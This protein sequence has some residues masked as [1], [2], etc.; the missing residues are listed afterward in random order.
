MPYENK[1][2]SFIMFPND[3]AKSD[4]AP[5]WKGKIVLEDG[6]EEQIV[7]WEKTSSKGTKFYSG[8]FEPYQV[9]SEQESQTSP[10][11]QNEKIPF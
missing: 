7:M 1:T 8:K 10:G 2:K 4:K 9:K 3:Y 6:T 11:S 5:Q